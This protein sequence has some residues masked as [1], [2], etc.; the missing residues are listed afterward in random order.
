MLR[1][2]I[3][4]LER[5]HMHVDYDNEHEDT[6]PTSFSDLRNN[7]KIATYHANYLGA[8]CNKREERNE[9][10]KDGDDIIHS[11]INNIDTLDTDIQGLQE[12]WE[13]RESRLLQ[14]DKINCGMELLVEI[15]SH[16]KIFQ[17]LEVL[18]II[19]TT[20]TYTG[21]LHN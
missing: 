17:H 3:S 4:Q 6:P 16:K 11:L 12:E 21:L 9:E 20:T 10:K 14:Q 5:T 13:A 7:I 2:V 18:I 15:L 1:Q 8:M 19:T